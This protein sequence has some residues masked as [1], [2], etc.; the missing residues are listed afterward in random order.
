MYRGERSELIR[1]DN[2]PCHWGVVT[3]GDDVNIVP[4]SDAI[5]LEFWSPYL[6]NC[7]FGPILQSQGTQEMRRQAMGDCG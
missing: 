7:E 5:D 6:P 1:V 3:D 4:R 2:G